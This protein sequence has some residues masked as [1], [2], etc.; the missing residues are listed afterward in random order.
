[1]RCGV[2]K[3]GTWLVL[4]VPE[5]TCA[6]RKTKKKLAT[7]EEPKMENHGPKLYLLQC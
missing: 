1:M 6:A 5:I 4:M 7:I 2:T 3:F